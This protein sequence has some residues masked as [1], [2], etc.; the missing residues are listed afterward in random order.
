MGV[1]R[2]PLC[3]FRPLWTQELNAK[4]IWIMLYSNKNCLRRNQNLQSFASKF[5]GYVR[6]K[7]AKDRQLDIHTVYILFSVARSRQLIFHSHFMIIEWFQFLLKIET[8][9]IEKYIFEHKNKQ[10]LRH[11][12][13]LKFSCFIFST[14]NKIES[15]TISLI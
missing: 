8:F 4:F 12:I 9:E 13:V 6:I 11:K 2:I 15:L 7:Y 3:T 5:G 1:W 10:K 14:K